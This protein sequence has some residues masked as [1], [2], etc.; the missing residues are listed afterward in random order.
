M[1]QAAE[2]LIEGFVCSWCGIY[3]EQSHGYPVLCSHC[4]RKQKDKKNGLQ[5]ATEKELGSE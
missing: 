1:G 5:K 3:F 2:D 4:Y